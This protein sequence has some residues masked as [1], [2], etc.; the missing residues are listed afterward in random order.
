M[1]VPGVFGCAVVVEATYGVSRHLP[2][3]GR[4]QRFVN[5]IRAVVQRGGRC[6]LPVVAL[7]RAQVLFWPALSPTPC[8]R[9][10]LQT[11]CVQGPLLQPSENPHHVQV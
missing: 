9:A 4:E 7:G 2:R 10:L 11:Y 1:S 3:E 8:S 5:M 6:L